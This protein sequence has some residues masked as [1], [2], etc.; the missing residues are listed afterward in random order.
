MG[1]VEGVNGVC[2]GCKWD[3]Y[4]LVVRCLSCGLKDGN[5]MMCVQ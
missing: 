3:V 1:C 4:V 2:G 5:F